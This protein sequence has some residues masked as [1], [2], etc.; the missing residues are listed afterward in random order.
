MTLL[1][2]SGIFG[3][4]EPLVTPVLNAPPISFEALPEESRRVL[5]LNPKAMEKEAKVREAEFNK[6]WGFVQFCAERVCGYVRF[7]PKCTG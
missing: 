5:S 2:A 1:E 6:Y 3:R 4:G 7:A